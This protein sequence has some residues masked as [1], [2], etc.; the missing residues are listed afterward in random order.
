MSANNNLGSGAKKQPK[1]DPK[2]SETPP[3]HNTEAN[4]DFSYCRKVLIFKLFVACDKL[5][6]CMSARMC[7][8]LMCVPTYMYSLHR[9]KSQTFETT[10]LLFILCSV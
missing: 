6:G 3:L 10:A 7:L 5:I 4:S 8:S 1:A 2:A 9:G